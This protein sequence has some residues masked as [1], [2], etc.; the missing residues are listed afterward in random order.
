MNRAIALV[1]TERSK[2]GRLA[3][4]AMRDGARTPPKDD[5]TYLERYKLLLESVAERLVVELRRGGWR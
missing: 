4:R 5:S 3:L 1:V 2:L